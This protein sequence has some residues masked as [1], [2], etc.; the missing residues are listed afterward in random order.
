MTSTYRHLVLRRRVVGDNDDDVEYSYAEASDPDTLLPLSTEAASVPDISGSGLPHS[1]NISVETLRR[2]GEACAVAPPVH[3]HTTIDYI[4]VGEGQPP[5]VVYLPSTGSKYVLHVQAVVNKPIASRLPFDSQ[6]RF[7]SADTSIQDAVIA[8]HLDGETYHIVPNFRDNFRAFL[9]S[10]L[11]KLAR[12]FGKTGSLTFVGLSGGFFPILRRAGFDAWAAR[13]AKMMKTT[14]NF[15]FLTMPEWRAE[16]LERASVEAGGDGL[17]PGADVDI[18]PRGN[19]LIPDVD[20]QAN[21]H[22][23]ASA[24][25]HCVIRADFSGETTRALLYPRFEPNGEATSEP[26]PFRPE[27]VEVLDIRRELPILPAETLAK[28]TQLHLLR[29]LDIAAWYPAPQPFPSSVHTVIDFVAPYLGRAT[30]PVL[31][32]PPNT[33]RYVLTLSAP[34]G[35]VVPTLT[36][37]L[38]EGIFAPLADTPTLRQAVVVLSPWWVKRKGWKKFGASTAYGG[39]VGAIA[40]HLAKAL[41][42]DEGLSLTVAGVA[43]VDWTE[44][45]GHP[46][47]EHGEYLPSQLWQ[48]LRTKWEEAGLSAEDSQKAEAAT[49]FITRGA[50]LKEIGVRKKF[51]VL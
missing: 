44:G 34:D 13:Y 39:V 9:D 27:D 31:W 21:W 20:L 47:E 36:P 8:I 10:A 19:R 16:L 2:T 4:T 5:P 7:A 43:P 23:D 42:G 45:D 30:P 1:L 22:D 28:F 25:V 15:R 37:E 33:R 40:G 3:A 51:E 6:L 38:A 12:I 50:W 29:R 18:D 14:G 49:R 48:L 32:L 41:A 35:K 24:L 26:L 17:V 46:D 11:L